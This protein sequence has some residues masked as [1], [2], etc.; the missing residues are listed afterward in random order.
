MKIY[1][2]KSKQ[3]INENIDQVFDFFSKPENLP[4]ITPGKMKFKIIT[5]KPIEMKEG[6]LIDYTLKIM[7]IPLRWTTL[8]VKYHPVKIFVDQQLKGPYSM[9]HHT[10]NFKAINDKETLIEDIV[11]Y[12]IPFG[13]LGRIAHSLWIKRDLENIFK[14]RSEKINEIFDSHLKSN[15][16]IDFIS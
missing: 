11:A 12:G 13:F 15:I 2:L 1:R 6:A 7:G 3:I 10:H 5:P 16:N 8:I 4:V 9:W 14:Y